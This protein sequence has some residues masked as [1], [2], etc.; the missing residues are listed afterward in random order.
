MTSGNAGHGRPR[1]LPGTGHDG[2]TALPPGHLPALDDSTRAR[3][4]SGMAQ[5][6][7]RRPR[8]RDA[9]PACHR[10][11]RLAARRTT[12]TIATSVSAST[13]GLSSGA[14]GLDDD[15]HDD[16][17]LRRPRARGA[18]GTGQQ[19][20]ATQKRPSTRTP[21]TMPR[22]DLWHEPWR[23]LLTGSRRGE[24]RF[25]LTSWLN[26]RPAR[27]WPHATRAA[28]TSSTYMASWWRISRAGMG[29]RSYSK[30]TVA[31]TDCAVH[32]CSPAGP[33]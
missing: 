30:V 21:A 17:E 25:S 5:M 19:P 26:G 18:T 15:R 2:W 8:A 12:T 11:D 7:R 32:W 6:L 9:D 3:T 10:G 31:L 28:S 23:V 20:L 14:D 16:R 1:A 33:A 13:T 27:R 22:Q 29:S 24:D 4:D